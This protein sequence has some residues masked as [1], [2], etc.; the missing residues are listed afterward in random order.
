MNSQNNPPPRVI[1]IQIESTNFT[2]FLGVLK[3][4]NEKQLNKLVFNDIKNLVLLWTL[5]LSHSFHSLLSLSLTHPLLLFIPNHLFTLAKNKQTNK[6]INYSGTWNYLK[7]RWCKDPR[8]S[9]CLEEGVKQW[10][11][12]ER[13]FRSQ[14]WSFKE[15]HCR[16]KKKGI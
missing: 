12:K 16:W 5:S 15:Q 10:S 13:N 1:S 6:I 4:W 8:T 7:S 14:R 9:S 2:V 3:F 11:W